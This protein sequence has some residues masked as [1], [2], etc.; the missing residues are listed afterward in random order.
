MVVSFDIDQFAISRPYTQKLKQ[1]FGKIFKCAESISS[2]QAD[3]F[4][5]VLVVQGEE[6]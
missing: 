4:V 1:V 2:V 3:N 5:K 6:G